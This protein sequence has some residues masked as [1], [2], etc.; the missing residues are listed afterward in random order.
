MKPNWLLCALA[1]AGIGI[2]SLANSQESK[3]EKPCSASREVD[4]FA[5]PPENTDEPP[6]TIKLVQVQV[7]FVGMSHEALTKFHFLAKPKT[8]DATALRQQVQD[9]VSKNE[10]K[11]LETQMLTTRSGQRTTSEAI[12]EFIYPTAFT[13]MTQQERDEQ[14][15][16]SE[17]PQIG[18]PVCFNPTTPSA[19]ETRNIGS[20]LEVEPTVSEDDKIV[21]VQC[22]P[23]LMWHTGENIW[24][25]GKDSMGNPFK[26]SMPNLYTIHLQLS[27]TC[28]SGQYTLAGVVSP[29]DDKGNT[30]LTRK[31]LVFVKC[32]VL[33]VK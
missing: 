21:D 14:A 29:K 33:E 27:L 28:I 10:A 11:V 5:D 2:A 23:E 26:Q 16:V 4:P 20:Q 22:T 9:M 32:D 6:P 3:A 24:H 12:Q 19:F 18:S 30:D 7:E 8:A 1:A 31:V 25:Q 13:P 17:M 15:S